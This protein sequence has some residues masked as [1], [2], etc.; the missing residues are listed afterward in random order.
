MAEQDDETHIRALMREILRA[1]REHDTAALAR[2]LA[3]EFTFSDPRGRVKSKQQWLEDIASGKLVF[4]S[5]EA[6]DVEFQHL[7][8]RALVKGSA[9]VKA[10]YTEADYN[11]TFRYLGVYTK[12][13][14]DWKLILTSAERV[15]SN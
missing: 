2:V 9:Q 5:I 6:G 3:D 12:H 1:F 8:D 11:G 14:A 13:G 4:D 10:R 15:E 7:G